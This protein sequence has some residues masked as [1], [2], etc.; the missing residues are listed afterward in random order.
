[1][2]NY[3][4]RMREARSSLEEAMDLRAELGIKFFAAEERPEAGK[5]VIDILTGYHTEEAQ[6][7]GELGAI[8]MIRGLEDAG[9]KAA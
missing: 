5:A 2:E 8:A 9:F 7:R 3:N 6:K 1:M 4:K